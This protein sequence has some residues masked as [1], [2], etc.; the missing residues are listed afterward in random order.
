MK[1]KMLYS[2]CALG[3]LFTACAADPA[4]KEWTFDSTK[5]GVVL[6]AYTGTQNDIS[7][8]ETIQ[9]KKVIKIEGSITYG[10][11][12]E[13]TLV[14]VFPQTVIKV[15]IPDTVSE[16]GEATFAKCE[17][18]PEIT[19]PE[20]VLKIDDYAFYGCKEL[21]SVN[22]G[23]K[24]IVSKGV[25][26]NCPDLDALDEIRFAD[27]P[28]LS[29]QQSV[30]TLMRKKG[31]SENISY[32]GI[33]G[34][35]GEGQKNWWYDGSMF[36]MPCTV[37]THFEDRKLSAIDV[38]FPSVQSAQ[39]ASAYLMKKYGAETVAQKQGLKTDIKKLDFDTAIS[40]GQD[41][42]NGG[43]VLSYFH[44]SQLEAEKKANQEGDL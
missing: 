13:L 6:K 31:Y 23:S 32:S 42:V 39:A 33:A 36:N 14:P 37:M 20:S 2:L 15:I 4:D 3:L 16:I 18:L 30:D 29:D 19:I 25:F 34:L 27:V 12:S 38:H 9:G 11:D 24:T 5:A 17:N 21:K 26:G 40:L 22:M 1:Q 8:P 7:I 43:W 28:W 35:A 10:S 44:R 41:R